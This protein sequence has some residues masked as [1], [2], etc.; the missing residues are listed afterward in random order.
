MNRDDFTLPPHSIEAEQSILGGLLL[1]NDAAD[2]LGPLRPDHFY[3]EDHRRIFSAIFSLIDR[4]MPADVLTVFEV[5]ES[6][7]EA[8]RC[9]GLAYLAEIADNTPSAANI[10]RYAEVVAER[11]LLRQ[12]M[13]TANEIAAQ[14]CQPG[15]TA[16]KLDFAQSRIMAL[17]ETSGASEPVLLRDSMVEHMT[18][19]QARY[20]RNDVFVSTGFPDI[21]E[22][23]RV[24]KPG[25]LI[26]VAARPGMGK[27]AFAL[28]IAANVA[29]S[30]TPTLFLSMEMSREELNDRMFASFGRVP[31]R[32]VLGEN[33]LTPMDWDRVTAASGR[34]SIMPLMMDDQP[35]LTL[36]DVRTKARQTKR[37]H[38]LGLIVI[39]YLQLMRG[40]GENRTQEVGSISR[41][42]KA[43]AKEMQVPIIALS[44]LN[45]GLEAR[46]NKRPMLSD[47]RESG[48]IE[49][50]ADVVWS[51]YRD[52]AYNEHSQYKGLAEL[53]W[54]KNRGGSSG[55]FTGLAWIG[56]HVLYDSVQRGAFESAA[57]AQVAAQAEAQK[58]QTKRR[59]NFDA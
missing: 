46:P 27:T 47:L 56:E 16:G 22:R 49:Q 2:R 40:D 41:G 35:A 55:G 6:S 59:A 48:D 4:R 42:L 38:G 20:D 36:W 9:G 18:T 57:A 19:M 5:L 21:D 33:P 28:R 25:R 10:R 52:E 50:D 58:A 34:F 8:E 3:R 15:D 54:L 12:L 26:I 31:L 37:K 14:A 24:L 51:L 7:G 32:N 23:S 13:Q 43:L 17:C 45:R 11:A 53:G 30:G 39:D 29:E 1:S 44:Q